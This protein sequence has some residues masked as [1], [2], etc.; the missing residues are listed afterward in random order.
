MSV[1]SARKMFRRLCED[2][3]LMRT[4]N[5]QKTREDLAAAVHLA[6]F[7]FTI[8]EWET[9][10]NLELMDCQEEERAIKIKEI[11]MWWLMLIL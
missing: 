3:D 7:N 10:Y 8:P 6:G 9:A 2:A 4:L 5:K 1:D 11:R